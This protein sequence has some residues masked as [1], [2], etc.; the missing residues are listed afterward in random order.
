MKTY[1]TL[2]ALV[3]FASI[4]NGPCGMSSTPASGDYRALISHAIA[5]E[6]LKPEGTAP[7]KV[8]RKDCTACKGSGRVK[9]GDG[10]GTME[11]ENCVAS[12]GVVSNAVLR[13]TACPCLSGEKCVCPNCGCTVSQASPIA[14][15]PVPTTTLPVTAPHKAITPVKS[16]AKATAKAPARAP[17]RPVRKAPPGYT[18]GPNGCYPSNGGFARRFGGRIFGR[19]R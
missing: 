13:T 15:K 19:R 8:A 7:V 2:I 14:P 9:T 1:A 17:V 18:C 10:L 12:P 11:C 16:V 5:T 4:G 6:S 3:A